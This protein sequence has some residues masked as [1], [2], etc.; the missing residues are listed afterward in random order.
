M[1]YVCIL[2]MLALM[3]ALTNDKDELAFYRILDLLP[4]IGSIYANNI[5]SALMN[6]GISLQTIDKYRNRDFYKYLEKL[7]ETVLSARN[8]TEIGNQFEILY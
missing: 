1:E 8:E 5:V 3:R 2:D 6:E 4:R 7:I